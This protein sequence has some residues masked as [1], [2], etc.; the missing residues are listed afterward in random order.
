MSVA[1]S[2]SKLPEL[3]DGLLLLPALEPERSV[4]RGGAWDEVVTAL[5]VE[6][7]YG[8]GRGALPTAAII[9]TQSVRTTEKGAARL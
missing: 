9:D 7:R 3:E 5:R 4:G 6:V 1:L 8:Q 2:A